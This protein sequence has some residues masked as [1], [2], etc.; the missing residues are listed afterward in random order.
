MSN[1][2]SGK[3]T[4]EKKSNDQMGANKGA[5]SNREITKRSRKLV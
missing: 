1:L 2:L 5:K 3:E 4:P